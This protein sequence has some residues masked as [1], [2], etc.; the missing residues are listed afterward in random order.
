MKVLV[1]I[2]TTNLFKIGGPFRLL[3]SGLRSK[4]STKNELS[5]DI[6]I[7]YSLINYNTEHYF[8]GNINEMYLLLQI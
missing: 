3:R 8:K 2:R 7:D 1:S 6:K 4:Y 5:I